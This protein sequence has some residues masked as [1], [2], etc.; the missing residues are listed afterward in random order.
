V[1]STEVFGPRVDVKARSFRLPQPVVRIEPRQ[2]LDPVWQRKTVTTSSIIST[3]L[4]AR[5]LGAQRLDDDDDDTPPKPPIVVAATWAELTDG[6]LLGRYPR[7]VAHE[8]ID[9]E[10]VSR[11]HALVVARRQ[12]IYVVDTGSTNGTNLRR[13]GANTITLDLDRRVRRVEDA[14]EL[15]LHRRRCVIQ[16]DERAGDDAARG[17]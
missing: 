1:S 16:I 10:G 5:A 6:V 9:D 4:R 3:P 7:C 14:D 2:P 8:S 13:P 12:R 11:V 15:W 17:H